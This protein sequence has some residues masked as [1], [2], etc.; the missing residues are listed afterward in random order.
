MVTSSFF[1]SKPYQLAATSSLFLLLMATGYPSALAANSSIKNSDTALFLKADN[2]KTVDRY[3]KTLRQHALDIQQALST[4]HYAEIT[5]S[6]HP[7]R[8][9]R[10]SMYGRVLP[11]SD[12]VFSRAQFAQYLRESRI[13]FTWGAKDG[14]GDPLIIPLPE[15]LQTWVAAKDF[16]NTSIGVNELDQYGVYT[17]KNLQTIYPSSEVVEFYYNGSDEYDGMDWRALRLVFDSYQGRRYLVAII[18]D[19]WTI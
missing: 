7:T 9:V 13:R 12:K 18:N 11:E 3:Q 1:K 5:E 14:T 17:I 15:Y 19:Q 8:G 2:G 4:G 6:I 16:D 10:F